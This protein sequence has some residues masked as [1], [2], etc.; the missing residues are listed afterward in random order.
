MGTNTQF[1][2]NRNILVTRPQE[3]AENLCQLIKLAGGHAMAYSVIEILPPLDNNPLINIENQLHQYNVAIFISPTAVAQTLKQI[4]LFPEQLKIAAIGSKTAQLLQHYG[5]HVSIHPDGHN[6][7][8]LLS[9]YALQPSAIAGKK[10]LIFRGQGGRA[11]LGDHLTQRG[12][13]IY[14]VESYRRGLPDI[15]PLSTDILAQLDVITLN[16][17]ESLNNLMQLNKYPAILSTPIIIASDKT[18]RNA[19][20]YGFK[21][22]YQAKNATDEACLSSLKK[23]FN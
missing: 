22:I 5:I 2:N 15:P 3:R 13:Q 14:Y 20:S 1:L 12:A 17:N 7:E 21:S 6:S 16:S 4:S 9:H 11:F 8:S 10:I 19:D 23:L 18:A